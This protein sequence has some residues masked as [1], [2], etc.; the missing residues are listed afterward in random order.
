M[1]SSA[2]DWIATKVFGL[3]E[4][5]KA[6]RAQE[7]YNAAKENPGLGSLPADQFNSALQQY[8][9][10]RI[11]PTTMVKDVPGPE[12]R[13]NFGITTD[14][15]NPEGGVPIS[16]LPTTEV[17]QEVNQE[18]F[19]IQ[20]GQPTYNHNQ[21]TGDFTLASGVPGNARFENSKPEGGHYAIGYD[22]NGD[23]VSQTP[24]KGNRDVSF[25]V[26]MDR[27]RRDIASLRGSGGGRGGETA[28]D[29]TNRATLAALLR[30]MTKVDFMGKPVPVDPRL[31]VAGRA[32][33]EALGVPTDFLDGQDGGATPETP[34][35]PAEEPPRGAGI[36]DRLF[37]TPSSPVPAGAPGADT[38]PAPALPKAGDEQSD[39]DATAYLK[40]IGAKVTPANIAWA[41]KKKGSPGGK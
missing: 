33:A 37:K 21:E 35:P 17:N 38:S 25:R 4:D 20:M 32:A 29:K 36:W 31:I 13:Q 6:R 34:I 22:D 10:D 16:V 28:E 5:E 1:P 23:V 18:S 15:P 24:I 39:A 14:Q 11:F 9:K 7:F 8:V 12:V 27:T 41:K 2:G 3:T 19:P 30:A 26:G 40:S